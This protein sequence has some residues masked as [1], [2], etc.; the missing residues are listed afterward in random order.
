MWTFFEVYDAE[1]RALYLNLA[2]EP[3]EPRAH[4]GLPAPGCLESFEKLEDA[5]QFA[6]KYVLAL[7]Y[8]EG[9]VVREVRCGQHRAGG[10]RGPG[11]PCYLGLDD[12]HC[13]HR[14]GTAPPRP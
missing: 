2:S 13:E 5:H 7:G 11:Q 12:F 9:K 3:E 6:R 1:A 4:P 10:C 14:E 8:H